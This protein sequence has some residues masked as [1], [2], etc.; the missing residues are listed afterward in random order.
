MSRFKVLLSFLVM[1]FLMT[2]CSGIAEEDQIMQVEGYDLN[3]T[4]PGNWEKVTKENPYDLYCT[5]GSAYMG[6]FVYYNIDLPEGETPDQ[7]YDYQ[8]EDLFAQRENMKIVEE[9]AVE[10]TNGKTITST[11]YSAEREGTKNYYYCNLIQF[12]GDVDRFMWVIFTG[13]PSYAEKHVEEWET[14]LRSVEVNG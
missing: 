14:I 1:V 10:V 7:I 4:L 13:L 2:G 8:I 6:M 12:E 9:K 5:N 11:M 3:L